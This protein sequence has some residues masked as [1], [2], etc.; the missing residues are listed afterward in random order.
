M[1]R[2]MTLKKSFETE[3]INGVIK[4]DMIKLDMTDQKLSPLLNKVFEFNSKSQSKSKIKEK[5]KYWPM[6]V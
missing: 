5:K 3:Y 6:K 1:I 4:L 2:Y